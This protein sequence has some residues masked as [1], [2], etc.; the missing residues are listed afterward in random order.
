MI[1]AVDSPLDDLNKTKHKR[2]KGRPSQA[3]MSPSHRLHSNRLPG[4]GPLLEVA[5]VFRAHGVAWRAANKGHISLAR[6]KVMSA[7]ARR[8]SAAMSR[9]APTAPMSTSPI[10]LAATATV[11]SV[12]R[13]RRRHGWRR[14][15]QSCCPCDTATLSSPCPNLSRTSRTRTNASS[16]IC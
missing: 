5:D 14:V 12:R 10:T 2:G 3:A 11:Q 13:V 16:V 1:A 9:G 6:L 15:R 8:R 4:S 7:V